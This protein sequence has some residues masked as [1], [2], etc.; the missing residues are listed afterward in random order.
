MDLTYAAVFSTSLSLIHPKIYV[1]TVKVDLWDIKFQVYFFVKMFFPVF[2][3][4]LKT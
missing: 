2:K 3:Q 1:P 4:S